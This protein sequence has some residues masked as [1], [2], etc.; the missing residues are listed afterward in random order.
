MATLFKSE[1]RRGRTRGGGWLFAW[2][3]DGRIIDRET[4]AFKKNLRA[5]HNFS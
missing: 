3:E 2:G 1:D 4:V 5:I